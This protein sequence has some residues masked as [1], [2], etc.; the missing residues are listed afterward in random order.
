MGWSLNTFNFQGTNL[1][2][3]RTL[4]NT[5]DVG[6]A[7]TIHVRAAKGQCLRTRYMSAAPKQK[8]SLAHRS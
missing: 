4:E 7:R 5:S 6:D 3:H 8:Y 2:V 1:V